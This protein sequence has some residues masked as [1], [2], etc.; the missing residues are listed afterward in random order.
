M[1][2]ASESFIQPDRTPANTSTPVESPIELEEAI[3]MLDDAKIN[4]VCQCFRLMLSEGLT[5]REIIAVI[6]AR[7]SSESR[8]ETI[9]DLEN[10]AKTLTLSPADFSA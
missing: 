4:L 10:I 3:E 2:T 8:Q 9:A 5:W 1:Q 7:V 6:S